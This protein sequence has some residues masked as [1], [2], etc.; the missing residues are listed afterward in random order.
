MQWPTLIVDDFFTD[1]HA[2]AKLSKKFK[3]QKGKDIPGTR[4]RPLHEVDNA[5]FQWSTRKM[6]ALLYPSQVADASHDFNVQWQASQ[7]FQRVPFNTYGEE[8]WI[9]SDRGDEFTVI[10][11]LSEHPNSGTCL[12]EGK[13]FD[14]NP[15]PEYEEEKRRF[16]KELKDLNRMEKYRNKNNSQFRKKVELFSTFNRLILYDGAHWHAS[17]N[18]ATDK[19]DRLTLITFF[20]DVTCKNIRYPITQMRRI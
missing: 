17:R 20:N 15:N 7:Y 6:L 14:A 3:Y 4:T 11:Y 2:I 8:G 19:K 5:F 9:H 13:Y 12:Y 18:D 1:P 16:Y 10:I